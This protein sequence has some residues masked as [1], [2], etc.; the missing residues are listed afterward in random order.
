MLQCVILSK[1]LIC[2]HLP[3]DVQLER[4][5]FETCQDVGLYDPVQSWLRID[6]LA[7]LIG[8]ADI[9]ERVVSPDLLGSLHNI[10]ARFHTENVARLQIY[11]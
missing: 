8:S 10:I 7:S 3:I 11:S 6:C 5:F 9:I 1:S 4:E 2:L